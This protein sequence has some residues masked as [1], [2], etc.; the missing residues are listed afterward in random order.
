MPLAV[1]PDGDHE[2][3]HQPEHD[4]HA[5]DEQQP[6]QRVHDD[7][8][9]RDQAD[10]RRAQQVVDRRHGTVV[11]GQPHRGLRGGEAVALRLQLRDEPVEGGDGLGPV[12]AGVVQQDDAARAVRGDRVGDDRVDARA[13]PVLAVGVGEHGD[14]AVGAGGPE[15][16]QGVVVHRVGGRGVGRAQQVARLA[17]GPGQHELGLGELAV[18]AHVR[19]RG[20]VGVGERVEPDLRAGV[21]DVA[22]QL[23]VLGGHRADDEERR[24]DLVAAQHLE[25]LRGPDRVRPV[26]EGQRDRLR[27]HARAHRGGATGVDD[28]PAV[29]DR[30]RD[31]VVGLLGRHRAGGVDA[32]LRAGQPVDQQQAAEHEQRD[33]DEQHAGPGRE[34]LPA[35]AGGHRAVRVAGRRQVPGA[36]RRGAVARHVRLRSRS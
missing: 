15:G 1:V 12:A 19:R 2:H 28:R 5:D 30:R 29:G 18:D 3:E 9:H 22:E 33:H 4:E 10:Q 14:V 27:R 16:A 13:L 17:Q 24:G 31:L 32:D 23:R 34:A 20:E 35:A 26:V 7:A 21:A 36:G 6:G 11:G 8:G 25:D